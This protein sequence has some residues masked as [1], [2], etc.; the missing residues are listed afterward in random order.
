[1]NRNRSG[2]P[3]ILRSF[4]S[5]EICPGDTWKVYIHAS[6]PGGDMK[7]IICAI[8]Q[9]GRGSYPVSYVSVPKGQGGEFSGFIYLNTG[10]GQSLPFI[11]LTLQV[12]IQDRAGNLS[13]PVSFLLAF[14]PRAEQEPPPPGLFQEQELGPIMTSID[15]GVIHP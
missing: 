15:F 12:E 2:L 9:P 8:S 1:M 11:H 5:R 14:N 7:T 13:R 3:V 6:D 10:A 4:A